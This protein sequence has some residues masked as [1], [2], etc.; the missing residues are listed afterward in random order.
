M[1]D[2]VEPASGD[3]IL[4]SLWREAGQKTNGHHY[5]LA[6]LI[7]AIA[8][9]WAFRPPEELELIK[10]AEFKFRP[11]KNGM[12]ERNRARLRVFIDDANFARLVGLPRSVVAELDRD[13]PTVSEAVRVKSALAVALLLVAPVREQN[14]ASIDL[15]RHIH[16]VSED[17][18]F[19]IFPRG[20]VKNARDLEY[21]HRAQRSRCSTSISGSIARFC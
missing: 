10:R 19:S 9:H 7:Y 12:T 4:E 21:P 17:V 8:K 14:L 13:I 1:S 18:G 16:R 6:R 11:P 3:A 20:E 5:N 15:D 2:L